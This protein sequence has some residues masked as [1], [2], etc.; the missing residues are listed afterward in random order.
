M[1]EDARVQ[2]GRKSKYTMEQ[3]KKQ[4]PEWYEQVIVG[5]K[6]T[7]GRWVVKED[8]YSWWLKKAY[9]EAIPGHRY[10]CVMALA[11][12]AAKCGILDKGRVRRDAESLLEKFNDF[13]GAEPF[14]KKD[15]KSAL[16]CLD[17]RFCNFSR[18][19]LES[20]TGVPMPPN[21]RNYRPQALHLKMARSNLEILSEDAGHALQGRPKGSGEKRDA[22][23]AYA[24][25][26]PGA[27]NS[28]IAK[29]LGVSRTTVVKWMK[30][31]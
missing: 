4:F 16:E 12:F 24:A 1:P 6:R 10:Y 2:P 20:Y 23:R 30:G 22:I 9:A 17:L 7:T 15:I 8:L 29:A 18:K 27:S 13:A 21:K 3:V 26:N 28:E 25:E 31:V 19:E 14:T 11:V 5:G